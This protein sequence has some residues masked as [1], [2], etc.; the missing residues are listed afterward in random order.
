MTLP[1]LANRTAK[2]FMRLSRPYFKDGFQFD[3][4][5]QWKTCDTDNLPCGDFVFAKNIPQ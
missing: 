4:H 2:S 1:F 3:R 5:T